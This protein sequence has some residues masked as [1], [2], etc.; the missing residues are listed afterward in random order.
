MTAWAICIV[1]ILLLSAGLI[2][3]DLRPGRPVQFASTAP[4]P[5]FP[6]A[7]AEIDILVA[8]RIVLLVIIAIFL[9]AVVISLFTPEGRKRLLAMAAAMLVTLLALTL[10]SFARP[11]QKP[12]EKLEAASMGAGQPLSGESSAASTIPFEPQPPG[13]L[14][15]AALAASSLVAAAGVTGVVLFVLRHRPGS[16][17]QRMAAQ[18]QAAIDSILSGADIRNVVV[19]CYREMTL[20][21]SDELGIQRQ[22]AI[23][24]SEFALILERWGLPSRPVRDL[25][26]VFEEIRYGNAAAAAGMPP[27]AAAERERRALDSLALI[28]RFCAAT[29]PRGIPAAAPGGIPA[30]T[31]PRGGTPSESR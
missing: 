18:S 1:A 19:R 25:T 9:V 8:V 22:T 5:R 15:W 4:V 27:G 13:W 20:I 3:V 7:A 31:A 24:P 30:A 6:G 28:A 16:A 14:L 21:V 11:S 2:G 10:L 26:E 29:A 17:R 23:T 12:A